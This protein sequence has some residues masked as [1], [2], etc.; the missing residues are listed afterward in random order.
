MDA[1]SAFWRPRGWLFSHAGHQDRTYRRP[2]N[3]KSWDKTVSIGRR[4]SSGY[5][6]HGDHVFRPG[7]LSFVVA[8]PRDLE[9]PVELFQEH[10][11]GPGGGEGHGGHGQLTPGLPP[12]ALRQAKEP[13]IQGQCVGGCAP[14]PQSKALDRA[15]LERVLPSIHMAYQAGA[16]QLA[17]DRLDFLP[18][19][20]LDLS[21]GWGFRQTLFQAAPPGSACS[22]G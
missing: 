17:L 1:S 19:C 16:G 21:L 20:G 2:L 3:Q 8:G 13:P 22:R 9:G 14:T 6:S 15:S 4:I 11:P 12:Q 18:R 7:T 10:D 5:G